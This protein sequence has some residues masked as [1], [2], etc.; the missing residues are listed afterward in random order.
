M[1]LKFLTFFLL[2][3]LISGDS[4]DKLKFFKKIGDYSKKK[5]GIFKFFV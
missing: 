4:A 3:Q 1:F 5:I 2:I